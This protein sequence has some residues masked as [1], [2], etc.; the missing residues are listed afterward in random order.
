MGCLQLAAE[1]QQLR[2]IAA[3]RSA[4]E[5]ATEYANLLEAAE[6]ESL[7]LQNELQVADERNR[8]L[9]AALTHAQTS[10]TQLQAAKAELEEQLTSM[11]VQPR[12]SETTG[13]PTPVDVRTHLLCLTD[14]LQLHA[15]LKRQ[16]FLCCINYCYI[17]IMLACTQYAFCRTATRML[18]S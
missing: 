4:S 9:A 3:T 18:E 15:V 1:N 11:G 5:Q 8:A 2:T 16:P 14:A 7:A 17:Y 12:V 13:A 6:A 10:G